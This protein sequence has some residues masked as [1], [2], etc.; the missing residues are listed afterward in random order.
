MI[1][2]AR[3]APPRARTGSSAD[4]VACGLGLFSLALGAAELLAP[5]SLA[6]SIGMPRDAGLVRAFGAR[7]IATGGAILSS[8]N[9]APWMWARV[10]GDVVD[11]LALSRGMGRDNPRRGNAC[12]AFAAV[13]G[14]TLVDLLCA[15][16]LS[17]RRGGAY[18]APDYSD[19][20]GFPR[21][22]EE[23]R[24]AAS[25]GRPA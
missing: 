21:P 15:R 17:D 7:E 3:E 22:A 2:R 1:D 6:R 11:L 14:I 13:A 23:M 19:R 9:A 18:L 8:S 16:A 12:L 4:A 5:H 10:A 24:G 20:S 25:G